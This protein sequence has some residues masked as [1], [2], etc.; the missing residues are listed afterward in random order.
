M[1]LEN[2][3]KAPVVTEKAIGLNEEGIYV[4]FIDKEATK[5]DIKIAFS[6]LFGRTVS[7]VKTT[8]LPKKTRSAGRS[9]TVTKRQS[10]RKAYVKFTDSTPFELQM[11]KK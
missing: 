7:S 4:F 10:K 9:G 1:I 11:V 8:R 5:V 6:T 2:V 3:I